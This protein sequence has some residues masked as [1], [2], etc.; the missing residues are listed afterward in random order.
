MTPILLSDC[1]RYYA[2]PGPSDADRWHRLFDAASGRFLGRATYWSNRHTEARIAFEAGLGGVRATFGYPRFPRWFR[3]RWVEIDG[4]EVWVEP[5]SALIR[6]CGG[7]PLDVWKPDINAYVHAGFRAAAGQLRAIDDA[8]RARGW[9][10]E[11]RKP[12]AD[13]GVECPHESRRWPKPRVE[14]QWP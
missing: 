6:E 12:L 14:L 10:F 11:A 1:R 7:E 8:M 13:R 4:R 9:A 2:A 5:V 3:R